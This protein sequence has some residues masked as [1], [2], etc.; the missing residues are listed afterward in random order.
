MYKKQK[1][2]IFKQEIRG[3]YKTAVTDQ[4]QVIVPHVW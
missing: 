1:L 3:L 2:F 4:V